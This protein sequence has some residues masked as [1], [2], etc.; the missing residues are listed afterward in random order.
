MS[1]R[2][3]KAMAKKCMRERRDWIPRCAV[4]SQPRLNYD[5]PPLVSP[6]LISLHIFRRGDSVQDSISSSTS[7]SVPDVRSRDSLQPELGE[8]RIGRNFVQHYTQPRVRP[9]CVA[10]RSPPF[11]CLPSFLLFLTR[12]LIA[13]QSKQNK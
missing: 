13:S 5:V 8:S 12:P 10:P 4:I 1:A 7:C 6:P 11:A 2:T 3:M 9:N